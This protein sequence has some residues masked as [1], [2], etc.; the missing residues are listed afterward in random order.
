MFYARQV[1]SGEVI[2][3]MGLQF[4]KDGLDF[5]EGD[6]ESGNVNGVD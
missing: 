4:V 3:P 6:G 1:T 5:S 2:W